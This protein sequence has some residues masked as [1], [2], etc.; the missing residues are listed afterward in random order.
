MR[1]QRREL[2]FLMISPERDRD[3]FAKR[4]WQPAAPTELSLNI[5]LSGTSV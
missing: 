4:L 3:I 1:G 2:I 5:K